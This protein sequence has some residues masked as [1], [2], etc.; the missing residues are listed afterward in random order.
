MYHINYYG[1]LEHES[2]FELHPSN[3]LL[4]KLLLNF[5]KE[6][7]TIQGK[8]Y[9]KIYIFKICNI[10]TELEFELKLNNVRNL[11]LTDLVDINIK[12]FQ[13]VSEII[14]LMDW[15]INVEKDNTSE[16]LVDLNLINNELKILTILANDKNNMYDLNLINNNFIKKYDKF[17]LQIKDLGFFF[18]FNSILFNKLLILCFNDQIPLVFKLLISEYYKKIKSECDIGYILQNNFIKSEHLKMKLDKFLHLNSL[19]EKGGF[20]SYKNKL[21]LD[22]IIKLI[23]LDLYDP[24]L[25]KFVKLLLNFIRVEYPVMSIFVKFFKYAIK[26]NSSMFNEIDTEF[27]KFSIFYCPDSGLINENKLLDTAYYTLCQGFHEYLK[28]KI[29]F[30]LNLL[31]I[32]CS[33]LDSGLLCKSNDIDLIQKE[34]LEIYINFYL[35]IRRRKFLD[36]Y[37]KDI[38]LL[39]EFNS[40]NIFEI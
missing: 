1:K 12:N 24:V 5:G 14:I 18:N 21:E 20:I 9:L 39:Y 10:K 23:Q 7:L 37:N 13:C 35:E 3:N 2:K 30:K 28:Y 31:N 33:L 16:I 11:I 32:N 19:K 15:I 38:D 25:K 29:F 8:I 4:N 40:L 6:E 36:F 17:K 27:F 22:E 26:T 34:T